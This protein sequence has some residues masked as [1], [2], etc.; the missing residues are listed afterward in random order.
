MARVLYELFE[1]SSSTSQ[2]VS[3]AVLR[4][5]DGDG[6]GRILE[7]SG[8]ADL[9][10]NC[11]KLL[12]KGGTVV[13]AGLSKKA[14]H[15]EDF[16]QDIL[17]KSLTI[18]SLHGRH[19]FSTWEKAEEMLHHQKVDVETVISHIIPLSKFEEAFE[20]LYSGK[21]CKILLDPQK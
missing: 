21:A 10:N 11:F 7:A 19:I 8:N 9:L 4:E 16:L 17:F 13:V 2:P 3:V 12:R 14:F 20:L 18:K 1:N 6:V 5:T 15:V